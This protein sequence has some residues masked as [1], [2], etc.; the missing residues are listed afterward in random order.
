MEW[1]KKNWLL[2][3]IGIIVIAL[4]IIAIVKFSKPKEVIPPP[5]DG[6]DGG[7]GGTFF[8]ILSQIPIGDWLG[9][10]FAKCDPNNQGY[11]TNGKPRKKCGASNYTLNNCDPKK[12]GYNKNGILDPSCGATTGACNPFECDPNRL[13]Y[14]MCGDKGFPCN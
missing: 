12:A 3:L 5:A 10:L 13:G 6:A 4:G 2:L 11:D 1:L 8:D 9:N 7:L 14:N